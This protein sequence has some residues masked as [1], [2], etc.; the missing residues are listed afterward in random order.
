MASQP[1]PKP[2]EKIDLLSRRELISFCITLAFVNALVIIWSAYDHSVPI[3]DSAWHLVQS[4]K[5]RDLLAHPH[6]RSTIWWQAL[7]AVNPLYPPFVYLVYGSL[8]LVLGPHRWVDLLA[9][10]LF[11]NVL[12][13]SMYGLGRLIFKST[14]IAVFAAVGVFIYPLV[15]LFVHYDMLD[16][17]G[18][19]MVSLALFCFTWW[20][21]QL[22]YRS[23]V[24]L[25][26]VCALAVLTKN[27]SVAFIIMP[28]LVS[29]LLSLLKKDWQRIKSLILAGFVGLTV[30][31]PW[32]IFG[33]STMLKAINEIQQ[34]S[35]KAGCTHLFEFKDN[36][37][38]YTYN[39][40]YLFSPFLLLLATLSFCVAPKAIHQRMFYLLLSAASGILVISY[41]HWVPLPKYA[42]PAVIPIVLYTG[43]A[44]VNYWQQKDASIIDCAGNSN[45]FCFCRS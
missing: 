39:L 43:W 44:S 3:Y 31:L 20:Q 16:L 19:A 27:N 13:S 10:L 25:G 37:F 5:C 4:L 34:T 12:C 17:P 23:S 26:V 15:F 42:L 9:R 45:M 14:A 18:L 33:L 6:L 8:H 1:S 7:L 41:F 32:L 36:A 2:R 22:S 38:Y 30:I 28:L 21:Q 24:V 29:F 11:S 35:N 40:S